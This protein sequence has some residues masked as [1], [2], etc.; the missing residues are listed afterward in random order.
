MRIIMTVLFVLLGI[1]VLLLFIA[2]F[3]KKDY[4][5]ETAITINKPKSEVFSYIKMLKHQANY[6]KW[7]MVD[8]NTKMD[9]T[10]IDGTTGFMAAW[11]SDNKQL[12]KGEQEI[13]R[14]IEGERI[15]YEIR[16]ERPFKNIA[17]T[18]M[19]TDS[20]SPNQTRVKWVFEGANKY[21]MNL[22]NL[23][24]GKLLGGDLQTSANN[25]KIELEK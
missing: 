8:P 10:G 11:D 21:P 15:D 18:Y 3:I 13:K 17:Q 22:M 6:N 23:F 14:I 7:W 12:G 1:I 5:I 19:A 16:F 2:L 4:S 20:I 9:F 25:L 24:I